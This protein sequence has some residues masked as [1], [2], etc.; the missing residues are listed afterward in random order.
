MAK[1][2]NVTLVKSL[3]GRHDKHIATAHSLG[4]RRI[5]DKTTQPDNPQTL[6]K[7]HQIRYLVRVTE[8]EAV[9]PEKKAKAA[10]RK[11]EVQP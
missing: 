2:Y 8:L 4:L 1:Q 10:A 6:G 9:K 7:L 5:G 11:Q 3:T